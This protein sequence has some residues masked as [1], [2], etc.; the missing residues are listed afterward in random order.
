MAEDKKPPKGA[1]KEAKKPKDNLNYF[2]DF[3]RNN[4]PQIYSLL[5]N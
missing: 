2:Q 4:L 3:S 5:G 1:A